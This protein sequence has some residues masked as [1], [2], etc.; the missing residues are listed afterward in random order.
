IQYSSIGISIDVIPHVNP[1]G[2]VGMD[3]AQEI[4]A[5]AD[6]SIV[7]TSG[8][9]AP[10]FTTRRAQTSVYIKD[11]NTVVIGGLMQDQ[12]SETIDKIPIL[13]D[14]P[15]LGELFKHTKNTKT[16]TELLIFLTPRVAS[17][18]DKLPAMSVDDVQHTHLVQNAVYEGAFQ[19][20]VRAMQAG[21]VP[22]TQPSARPPEIQIGGPRPA[23]Q[24]DTS[25]AQP[26]NPGTGFRPGGRGG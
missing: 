21:P 5:L 17:Q 25:T 6:S 9:T 8:V 16:K 3:I 7:V 14:I 2:L 12:K 23:T 24:P 15:L 4:S 11:G 20:H 26:A 19:E 18:P 13:G 10:V 22:A 1:D